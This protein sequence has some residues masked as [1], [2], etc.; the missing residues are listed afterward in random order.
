MR[1]AEGAAD[2]IIE[3]ARVAGG[4]RVTGHW[5]KVRPGQAGR[6]I[7]EEA[8][9]MADRIGVISQGEILVVEDKAV[10]MARLGKRRLT[11][12]LQQSLAALPPE[13]AA[14]DLAL[15]PGM[16]GLVYTFEAEGGRTGIAALLRRLDDLGI[17]Y[18]DLETHQS[19]LEDIFVDL[20]RSRP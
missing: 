20:V 19:S 4:R 6:R 9:D 15:S 8:E 16:D 13:L 18:R 12:H 1:D 11:V 2:S 7:I 5:E 17:D 3:Q 10:L 14:F